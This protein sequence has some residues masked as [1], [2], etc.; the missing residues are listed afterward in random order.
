M[1]IKAKW[2]VE[3][4][5]VSHSAGTPI[6]LAEDEEEALVSSGLAEYTDGEEYIEA[7]YTEAEFAG[8]GAEAQKKCL[9]ELGIDPGSNEKLRVAQYAEWLGSGE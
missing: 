6:S 4:D 3:I 2:P 7:P 5:G 1:T 9:E 8:L